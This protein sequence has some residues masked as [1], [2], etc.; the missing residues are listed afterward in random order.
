LA[1]QRSLSASGADGPVEHARKAVPRGSDF[2]D[3]LSLGDSS[4]V[5]GRNRGRNSV[6]SPRAAKAVGLVE[7]IVK[8]KADLAEQV[9]SEP[10]KYN[11]AIHYYSTLHFA[12]YLYNCNVIDIFRRVSLCGKGI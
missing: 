8:E 4:A 10:N 7:G 2:G 1:S 9:R 3:K 11:S 12:L 6:D 5:G